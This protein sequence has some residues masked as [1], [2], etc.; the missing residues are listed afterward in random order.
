MKPSHEI[1]EQKKEELEEAARRYPNIKKNAKKLSTT[2]SIKDESA[3]YFDQ[4]KNIL[5]TDGY[6]ICVAIAGYPNGNKKIHQLVMRDRAEK[7]LVIRDLATDIQRTGATSIILINE[8]W[9]APKGDAQLT[10]TG[11]ESKSLKEALQL[12]AAN[13]KGEIITRTVNFTKDEHG[14]VNFG[15]EYT[16]NDDNAVNIVKPIM[17]VWKM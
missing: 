10:R 1:V 5:K 15:D 11:I 4:A 17:E 14:T 8:V 2:S 16:V 9:S 3:F 13:S 6:H 12:I 7:H